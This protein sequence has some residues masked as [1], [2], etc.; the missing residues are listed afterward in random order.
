[1]FNG[2]IEKRVLHA[3]VT[4]ANSS[5][6]VGITGSSSPAIS[7]LST[8]QVFNSDGGGNVSPAISGP[9]TVQDVRLESL[10]VIHVAEAGR[11][12]LVMFFV[13]LYSITYG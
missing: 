10:M 12:L 7:G 1:M 11:I 3:S 9:S 8:V 13:V 5:L 2:R 6:G 4:V